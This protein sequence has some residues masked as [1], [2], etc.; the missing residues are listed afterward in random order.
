MKEQT[1]KK[2]IPHPPKVIRKWCYCKEC[3]D[4]FK[5]NVDNKFKGL[6]K[7]IA[8]QRGI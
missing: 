4:Y 3:E 6:K 5:L 7:R 2:K 1:K 8:I